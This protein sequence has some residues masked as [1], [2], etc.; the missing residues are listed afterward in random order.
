MVLS[1]LRGALWAALCLAGVASAAEAERVPGSVGFS[2]VAALPVPSP[3]ATVRYG[4]AAP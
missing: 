2:A 1:T 4:P 3:V